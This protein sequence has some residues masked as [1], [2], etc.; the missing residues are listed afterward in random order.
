MTNAEGRLRPGMFATA[1][2]GV[3][4]HENAI[5]IPVAG[6]VMEK[7]NAFVFKHVGGKA[8]KTAVKPGF[9]DGVLVEIPDLAESD[10]ILLPGATVLTDG[11]EVTVA[12]P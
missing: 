11:Q 9:N 4:K 6:L 5:L 7:T 2:V 3:E 8:V 10:V 12:N 1:R